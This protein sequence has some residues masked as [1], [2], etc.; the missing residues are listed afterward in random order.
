MVK[1]KGANKRELS[2]KKKGESKKKEKKELYLRYIVCQADRTKHLI[3]QKKLRQRKKNHNRMQGTS[4][5]YFI[6][7]ERSVS[8][9]HVKNPD[10][11][12]SLRNT[13]PKSKGQFLSFLEIS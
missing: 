3:K 5:N 9:C 8:T 11:K 4:S 6:V 2:Y 12:K 13:S 7:Q 10:I 1:E